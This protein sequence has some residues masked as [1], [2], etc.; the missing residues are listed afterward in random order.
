MRA[1]GAGLVAIAILAAAAPAAA[2]A[3]VI[4]HRAIGCIV[5]GRFPKVGACLAPA[6]EVARARVYFRPE[7]T[8]SWFYVDMHADGACHAGILPRP[9]R[10]LLHE[11]VLYYVEALGREM[12]PART[13]EI[14]AEVVEAEADCRATL[15][16][17]PL[18]ASGPAGVYPGM[19]P[20]F[21]GAAGISPLLLGGAAAA[22][23]AG[24]A[25]ASIGDSGAEAPRPAPTTPAT[26][27][28]PVPTA[29]P[30]PPPITLP[31]A[32][33]CQ[34]SPR[35]GDAPLAVSFAAFPSGGI[36][37][38]AFVWDFGDGGSSAN[39]SPSH[40][41]ATPG[42]YAAT[43]RVAAGSETAACARTIA[44]T[45]ASV[46]RRILTVSTSGPKSFAVGSSPGAI[47]CSFPPSGADTCSDSFLDGTQVRLTVFNPG[48]PGPPNIVWSGPCDTV[49]Q[50][51]TSSNCIVTMDADKQI[52]A[53]RP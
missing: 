41:Y 1:R 53:A 30:T 19:P 49:F 42:G 24:V 4:D 8:P 35:G 44:V 10:A 29:P 45:R 52:H 23:G 5:V 37:A 22:V 2:A 48:A 31:L 36:G 18:S 12:A 3:P 17:A 15:V 38:Y 33:S 50:T 46:P 6:G 11:K 21:S 9:G 14:A 32:L 39:P 40:T 26:T 34:A 51:N 20:G 43:V 7:T 27:L 13:A 16:V 28:P 47:S 25:I